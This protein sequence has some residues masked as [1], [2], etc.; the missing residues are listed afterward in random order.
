EC[1]D[2]EH[3][4]FCSIFNDSSQNCKP[5]T[6]YTARIEE[7]KEN[8]AKCTQVWL[9]KTQLEGV[10]VEVVLATVQKQMLNWFYAFPYLCLVAS[11][12]TL[13]MSDFTFTNT[14]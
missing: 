2:E 10:D 5:A 3:L 12:N 1:C 13:A 9:S 8:A 6:P 7:E 14:H 4:D 11:L